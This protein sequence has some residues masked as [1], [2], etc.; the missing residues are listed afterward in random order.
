LRRVDASVVKVRTGA[1]RAVVADATERGASS[2]CP[3]RPEQPGGRRGG[4]YLCL[5]GAVWCPRARSST[6]PAPDEAATAKALPAAIAM[7][8]A[9][10]AVL[11]PRR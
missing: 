11:R 2:G 5:T 3:T 7:E 1:E 10:T 8:I 4:G 6:R 9:A